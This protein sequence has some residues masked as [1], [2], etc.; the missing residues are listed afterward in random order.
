MQSA[1]ALSDVSCRIY[2]HCDVPYSV[3]VPSQD[4]TLSEVYKRADAFARL[5]PD[6]DHF[7]PGEYE[8]CYCSSFADKDLMPAVNFSSRRGCRLLGLPDSILDSRMYLGNFWRCFCFESE[9][10]ISPRALFLSSSSPEVLHV[11]G[12]PALQRVLLHPALRAGGALG[13]ARLHHK[14]PGCALHSGLSQ[15]LP[16]MQCKF[17]FMASIH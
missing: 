11:Y 1:D 12:R 9:D 14:V 17:F 3:G 2:T 7:E 10:T 4:F 13:R 15:R 6:F 8:L 16:S 5:V